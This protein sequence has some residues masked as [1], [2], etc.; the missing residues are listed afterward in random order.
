MKIM[1]HT[2]THLFFHMDERIH[3]VPFGE[4]LKGHDGFSSMR[5]MEFVTI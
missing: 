5:F 4:R 3:R 1:T 2:H